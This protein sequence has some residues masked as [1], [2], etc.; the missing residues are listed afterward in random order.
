MSLASVCDDCAPMA[1][2]FITGLAGYLGS[3]LARTAGAAGWRVGGTVHERPGPQGARRVDVRDPSA[4][5]AAIAAEAPDV[6]VHTAYRRDDESATV[7]GARIVAEAAAHA[8][9]RLIHL[10]SDLVFGGDLVRPLTEQDAPD[11]RLD[12]GRWKARAEELVREAH[13]GALLLRTSLI[14]GE[15]KPSDHER[16]ALEAA[17]GA[18][19]VTFFTD[20]LRNPVEVTDLAN[21]ILELAEQDVGG[22]LHVAGADAMDRLELARLFVE[23]RGRDPDVLRGGPGSP[24]RPKDCRLDSSHARALL[25]TPL[26]GAREVLAP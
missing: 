24:D 11:P 9:A 1:S 2:I 15:R 17:D 7:D 19:D 12:Y 18:E 8:G 25:R 16:L 26:R 10:S 5:G 22:P 23:R 3:E 6:V 20:E 4:V 14:Y 13:P 21:A